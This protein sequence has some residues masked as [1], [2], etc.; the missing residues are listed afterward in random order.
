MDLKQKIE[1]YDRLIVEPLKSIKSKNKW[2][3][4]VVPRYDGVLDG[5]LIRGKND[6][7]LGVGICPRLSRKKG[8][9]VLTG[10]MLVTPFHNLK[11][12]NRIK[13]LDNSQ[14]E[15]REI[16]AIARDLNFVK[17][18]IDTISG[19]F[20]VNSSRYNVCDIEYFNWTVI[21]AILSTGELQK[22]KYFRFY[23]EEE[24]I[25]PKPLTL[26]EREKLVKKLYIKR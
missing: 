26:S 16:D 13:V 5:V 19:K 21:S 18:K 1:E 6:P 9:Y 24:G 17:E 4:D 10:S 2:V 20:S 23:D 7:V 22:V 25:Y 15:I 8:E 14:D 12:R 3:V 11:F